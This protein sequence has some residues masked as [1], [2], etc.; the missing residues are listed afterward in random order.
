MAASIPH[1]RA[2][3]GST[4]VFAALILCLPP[5]LV[6]AEMVTVT[7]VSGEQSIGSLKSWTVDRLVIDSTEDRVFSRSELQA[8]TFDRSNHNGGQ[9]GPSVWLTNGD[10]I[11]ARSVSVENDLLSM[12]WP[13]RS[14][15]ELSLIPLEDV[16]AMVF[17]WPQTLPER[18]R[19]ITDL[20]TLPPGSDVIMLSNGD[21]SLGE[22]QRLDAAFVE[23]G[24]GG[25]T[26]KLDRGRVR[27]IRLDP[28]LATVTRPSGRRTVVTL[29]DGSQITV[30]DIEAGNEMAQLKSSHLGNVSLPV[31]SLTACHM[32]G[33]RLIPISDYEPLE[34]KFTPYLSRLWEPIRNANA[35]HGPLTLQG[36]EFVTGLGMHSRMSVTYE[37][38]GNE[39][40]FRAL[41]G[42]DDVANGMGSVTFAVEL[43]GRRLWSSPEMTG[44]S[45]AKSTGPVSLQ[46]GQKLT[47]I[48]EFGEFADVSDYANWCDA[49]LILEPAGE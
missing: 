29:I 32:F 37:L 16:A 5:F 48:A 6:A 31:A 3:F 34:I 43:D 11:S 1:C 9:N 26:V 14:D 40:E 21:R 46:G 36:M 4:L 28:E 13:I 39:R 42:I 33:D 30:S 27:A 49:F 19:L 38:H 10:R 22:F 47:L 7:T 17:E 15:L 2:H 44:K 18:L 8:V 25:K 20:E 12:A 23:L 45:S 41:V 24:V 35:L